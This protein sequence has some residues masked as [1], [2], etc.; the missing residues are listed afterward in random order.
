MAAGKSLHK[1]RNKTKIGGKWRIRPTRK[2]GD[3]AHTAMK[4]SVGH[5]LPM[6]LLSF[7]TST[8]A[9]RTRKPR[10]LYSEAEDVADGG[11]I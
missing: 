4:T 1:R 10:L 9:K 6:R 11:L 7:H 5:E 3:E 8:S 2:F